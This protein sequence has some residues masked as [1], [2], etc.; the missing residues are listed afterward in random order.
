[1]E[2]R[3]PGF[4]RTFP[5]FYAVSLAL[6]GLLASPGEFRSAIAIGTFMSLFVASACQLAFGPLWWAWKAIAEKKDAEGGWGA[7]AKGVSRVNW[8]RVVVVVLTSKL[9]FL[10]SCTSGMVMSR[11]A[12]D[13]VTSGTRGDR[14]RPLDERMS[15][16]ATVPAP[17]GQRKMVAVALHDLA[18]FKQDNPGYSF[19]PPAGKGELSGPDSFIRTE[20]SV[21]AAGP[22]KVTVKTTYHNDENHVLAMYGATDKEIEPLYTKTNHDF[23]DFMTGMMLGVPLAVVLALL[24]FTLKW[25]LKRTVVAAAANESRL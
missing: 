24:G 2:R 23:A 11:L 10:A 3:K 18:K 12:I 19:A 9:F 25:W 15:V 21:A 17:A 8:T 13:G 20:Y 7:V 5:A 14:V 1:M 4:W 6:F 16:I 22:G